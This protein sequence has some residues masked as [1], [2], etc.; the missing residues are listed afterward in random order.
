MLY[1]KFILIHFDNLC[2][3]K[4]YVNFYVIYDKNVDNLYLFSY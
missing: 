1:H 4:F 3:H 2:K